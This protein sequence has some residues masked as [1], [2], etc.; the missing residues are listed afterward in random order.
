MD[1]TASIP[2]PSLLSPSAL[3]HLFGCLLL[4]LSLGSSHPGYAYEI[5]PLIFFSISQKLHHS[6]SFIIFW[7]FPSPEVHPRVLVPACCFRLS[8]VYL[9]LTLGPRLTH[10]P[11]WCSMLLSLLCLCCAAVSTQ[12]VFPT[13]WLVEYCL[14]FKIQ[15]THYLLRRSF[16][17]S[18]SL[19]ADKGP[20]ALQ[21]QL[22]L[23]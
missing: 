17:S 11:S 15:L 3:I 14:S 2:L 7:S 12:N 23:H 16:C 21:V 8:P 22:S 4:P 18:S 20:R 6:H 5:Q 10:L 13:S 19:K 9:C 1:S